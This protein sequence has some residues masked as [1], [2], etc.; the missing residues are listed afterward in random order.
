[1]ISP[2]S[3]NIT[4]LRAISEMAVAMMVSWVGEKPAWAASSRPCLRAVT[5]SASEP[6]GM[7][8]SPATDAVLLRS[9][10]G[11]LSRA[12]QAQASR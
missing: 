5:T 11:S 12:H 1:M 10:S 8:T 6:M 9:S 7:R 2:R 4:M 3:A